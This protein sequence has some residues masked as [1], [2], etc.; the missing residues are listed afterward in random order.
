MLNS[1]QNG[2][3]KI[4]IQTYNKFPTVIV[5]RPFGYLSVATKA[6]FKIDLNR[7]IIY[8]EVFTDFPFNKT[9]YNKK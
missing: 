8:Y 2:N 5:K 7:T 3:D 4:I 6:F 1:I 9:L